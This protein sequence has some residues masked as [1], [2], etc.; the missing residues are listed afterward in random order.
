[1]KI[2]FRNKVICFI[3]AGAMAFCAITACG[4]KDKEDNTVLL[5]W[6]IK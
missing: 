4:D 6:R 5:Y 2:N 3:M 1:M